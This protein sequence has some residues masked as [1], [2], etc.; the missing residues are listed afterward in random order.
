MHA[1]K[2]G[3][4]KDWVLTAPTVLPSGNNQLVSSG[5][6]S[7]H[8]FH[9]LAVKHAHTQ[10]YLLICTGSKHTHTHKKLRS[11]ALAMIN[12]DE[13]LPKLPHCSLNRQKLRHFCHV[14]YAISW[15][16]VSL[17]D[18]GR[19]FVTSCLCEFVGSNLLN[20]GFFFLLLSLN[21]PVPH[22]SVHVDVAGSC[23]IIFTGIDPL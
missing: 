4:V 5:A 1:C 19:L 9:L 3:K 13:H 18:G 6:G 21:P 20:V 22:K 2:Q 17:S 11:A 8:F 10:R 14:F 12:P 23:R 15:F 7:T 16:P